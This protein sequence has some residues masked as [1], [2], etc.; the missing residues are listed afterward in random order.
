LNIANNIITVNTSTPAVRFGGIAV[1]DS[2]SLGTGLTGSLLWDS[3]N[4][5]WVYT[6]PSG[7]SYSG[8]MMISG[9]RASSLGEEQGTT[10]NALMKGQGG[11]HIT[12]SGIFESGSNVGIGTTSPVNKL[13][14]R[15]SNS[16]TYSSSSTGS[17]LTLYNTSATTNGFVGIDFISEPTTGNAG[18]AAIN[19]TVTGNGTSDLTFSTRN[20][21]MGEKMR[22]TSAGNIGIGTSDVVSTNL[23]GSVTIRKSY[24]G[25]TPNG[26]TTQTY[27]QNQSPLFLF[28]R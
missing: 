7:S 3:Q 17:A 4:N 11:D 10:F 18:R 28:G 1:Q 21:D 2:G 15:I 25:D 23:V 8:G 27:Y 19:M 20:T 14:I 12:S 16:S 5:H 6:N 22:I 26:T 9:P 13:D 24:E